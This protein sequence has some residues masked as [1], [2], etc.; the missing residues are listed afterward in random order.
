MSDP[1]VESLARAGELDQAAKLAVSRGDLRRGARLMAL[2]GRVADGVIA[3]LQAQ[4][5]RLAT[6]LA[7]EGGDERVLTALCDELTK[8]PARASLGA[9]Q[10]QIARRDDVA[11]RLLEPSAPLEAAACWTARGEHASA[12]RCYAR[13]GRDDEARDAYERHLAVNPEDARSAIELAR[14][15]AKRG[16]D[17]GATRALQSAESTEPGEETEAMLVCALSRLCLDHGARRWIRALRQRD[18]AHPAEPSDYADRLPRA[19]GAERRYAGRYRVLR[20]VGSGAT[21]RVLEAVD[22][23]TGDT[24]A[25][26]VLTMSDD[27]S[28]AFGRFLREAEIARTMD[29]PALVRMRA[30]DPEGPCIV[31]DWMPGG[32]L[33]DRIATLSLP[34]VRAVTLRLL[35]ALEVL[36]RNGVVHR[37]VKPSNVLFDPAGQARLSDLGA[38]HLGDLGATVTGGLVGSLPYMAPEQITG[39]AVQASTDLYALGCVL[40]QMLTGVLPF[41]GPDYVAEHLG[42]EAPKVSDARPGMPAAFDDAVASLLRK[43]PDARPADVPTARAVL[44]ALPWDEPELERRAPRVDAA[45]EPR[46]E[47]AESARLTPGERPGEWRDQRMERTVE[48]VEIPR[49]Q[50]V[51]AQRWAQ[52]GATALQPIHALHEEGE[53]DAL[54]LEPLGPLRPLREHGAEA[55]AAAE[56]ALRAWRPGD[57]PSDSI[58]AAE[59]GGVAVVSFASALASLGPR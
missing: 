26:K 4:D 42:V 30:L 43:D 34:E 52:V 37:D 7:L 18:I 44:Q 3:A 2:A 27:R 59:A 57:A 46:E 6:E 38:A 14:L 31:Y 29:H 33:G 55:R 41:R 5:W 22:E 56:A 54:W 53:V 35:A 24:V 48:R 10:A 16:D 25:L 45:E 13:A 15:R 50:R 23:L 9:A 39:G 51:R 1:E 47:P 58:L 20:E 17:A 28:A 19:E 40:Y 36:H 21:G 12:A 32:T 49:A 8:D 11:A